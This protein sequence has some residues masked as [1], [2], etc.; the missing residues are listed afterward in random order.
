MSV[1]T[2]KSVVIVKHE[3]SSLFGLRTVPKQNEKKV[4][5]RGDVVSMTANYRGCQ[6]ASVKKKRTDVFH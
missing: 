6:P 2:V 3:D 1:A 4:N 5:I